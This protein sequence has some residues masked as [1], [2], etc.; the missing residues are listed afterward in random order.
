M[1]SIAY[2]T[3]ILTL[4]ETSSCVFNPYNETFITRKDFLDRS[5]LVE[6]F[7]NFNPPSNRV[8]YF[9]APH[10][11]G[12]TMI[13][14]MIQKFCEI[15]TDSMHYQFNWTDTEAYWIF[16]DLKIGQQNWTFEHLARYPVIYINFSHP[17]EN[18]FMNN[19]QENVLFYMNRIVGSLYDDFKWLRI[20][21]MHITNKNLRFREH[22]IEFIE[23]SNKRRLTRMD[24]IASIDFLA[25]MLYKYYNRSRVI[26]LIDELDKPLQE[27][28]ASSENLSEEMRV[29]YE[30][31]TDVLM[32]ITQPENS[33]IYKILITG[34]SNVMFSSSVKNMSRVDTYPFLEDHYFNLFSGFSESNLNELFDWYKYNDSEKTR[35][36][37]YY[38]PYSTKENRIPIYNSYSIM[39]H[40]GVKERTDTSQIIPYWQL[41]NQAMFVYK[42]LNSYEFL[43]IFSQLSFNKTIR[44]VLPDVNDPVTFEF[45]IMGI[46]SHFDTEEFPFTEILIN[47]CLEQ[48]YLTYTDDKNILAV[49]SPEIKEVFE[50]NL[51]TYFNQSGINLTEIGQCFYMI[52]N[53]T[54]E[55]SQRLERKFQTVLTKQFAK[56]KKSGSGNFTQ[57]YTFL[58]IINLAAKILGVCGEFFEY[59]ADHL[60]EPVMIYEFAESSVVVHLRD[61]KRNFSIE[62]LEQ[63]VQ[64]VLERTDVRRAKSIGINVDKDRLV[65]LQIK[66]KNLEET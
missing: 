26:I 13:L 28:L 40:F 35:V 43:E 25:S 6:K 34:V 9:T 41:G 11:F 37:N 48:G 32:Q 47:Y 66:V 17:F 51:I 5:D 2:C 27:A 1:N 7:L 33:Y 52:L 19:V 50:S 31:I 59:S 63:S 10:N 18:I 60:Q 55:S 14:R 57:E 29:L 23:M 42:F 61:Q 3:I 38:K 8:A 46:E 45:L 12:K 62:A 16:K 64:Q 44:V 21:C 58:S 15:E 22:E 39:R 56:V 54:T 65:D 36:R 24:I 4:I 20:Y 49:P 53:S 30:L